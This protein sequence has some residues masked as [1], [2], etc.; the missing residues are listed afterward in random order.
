M[1]VGGWSGGVGGFIGFV[2]LGS[3]V[4]F[5]VFIYFGYFYKYRGMVVEV[6]GIWEGVFG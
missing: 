1:G 2:I 3:R 6:I 4:C 5:W